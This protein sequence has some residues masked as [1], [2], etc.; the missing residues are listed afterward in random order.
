[1]TNKETKFWIFYI[2]R[3]Q[4][5][6]I[7][8][9]EKYSPKEYK[10]IIAKLDKIGKAIDK[11]PKFHDITEAPAE[12]IKVTLHYSDKLNGCDWYLATLNPNEYWEMPSFGFAC[13]HNWY[14]CAELGSIHIP[15]ILQMQTA[16]LDLDWDMNTTLRQVM[17][18]YKKLA[19]EK[20]YL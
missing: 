15:Q 19:K 11:M 8:T 16:E 13:L 7:Q 17:D 5:A 10:E 4:L 12:E 18:K 20:G 3:Y 14:D 1:M 2:P 9:L 6:V